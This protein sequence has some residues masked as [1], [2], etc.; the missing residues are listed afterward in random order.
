MRN[1]AGVIGATQVCVH[2]STCLCE[3]ATALEIKQ[4]SYKTVSL[5]SEV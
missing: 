4:Y 1:R 5:T 3:G 2:V